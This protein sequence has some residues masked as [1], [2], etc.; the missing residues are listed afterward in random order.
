MM[1]RSGVTHDNPDW[2]PDVGIGGR[3]VFSHAVQRG[4]LA[5]AKSHASYDCK[6]IGSSEGMASYRPNHAKSAAI[7]GCTNRMPHFGAGT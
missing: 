1:G 6:A 4:C 2:T 5:D 7:W 3:N